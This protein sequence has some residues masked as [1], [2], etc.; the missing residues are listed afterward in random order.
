MSTVKLY[1][2]HLHARKVYLIMGFQESI[3]L[4]PGNLSSKMKKISNVENII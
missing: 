1:T 2:K 4:E 3:S